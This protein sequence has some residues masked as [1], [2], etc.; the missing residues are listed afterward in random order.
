MKSAVLALALVLPASD[1][2]Q[3]EPGLSADDIL[4]S[5][6]TDEAAQEAGLPHGFALPDGAEIVLSM[7]SGTSMMVAFDGSRKDL[8]SHFLAEIDRLGFELS[9]QERE[10]GKTKFVVVHPSDL[11]G[12]LI[13]QF[14][15]SR[16]KDQWVF[17]F[18]NILK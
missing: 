8:V 1:Y 3:E 4:E 16:M 15:R 12:E 14:S 13:I 10:D 2:A 9:A 7:M 17:L 5:V 11:D 6:L 18:I